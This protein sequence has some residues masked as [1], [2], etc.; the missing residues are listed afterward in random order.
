MLS[1]SIFIVNLIGQVSRKDSTHTGLVASVKGNVHM[2][3][4][5]KLF[6][7]LDHLE[8]TKLTEGGN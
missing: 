2:Y 6:N 4:S 3:N 8:F 1:L 7:G 5:H